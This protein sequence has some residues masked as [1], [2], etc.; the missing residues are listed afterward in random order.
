M[1]SVEN[2]ID[3]LGGVNRPSISARKYKGIRKGVEGMDRYRGIG[4][5][6]DMRMYV[7]VGACVR[8]RNNNKNYPYPPLYKKALMV[9]AGYGVDS[10]WIVD[11]W[12]PE[13]ADENGENVAKAYK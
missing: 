4:M 11:G 13:N 8:I 12:F 10:L 7:C 2:V 5:C 6:A 9:S 3:V 1:T